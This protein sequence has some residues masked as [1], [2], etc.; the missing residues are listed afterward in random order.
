MKFFLMLILCWGIAACDQK[1]S[2]DGTRERATAEEEANTKVANENLAK[3]AEKMEKD[4]AARHRFYSSLQG[5]YEGALQVNNEIYKISFTFVPSIPPYTGD[6]VRQLSEIENELNNLYFDIDVSQWHSSDEQIVVKCPVSRIRPNMDRGTIFILST[7]CRNLYKIS[8]SED[9][10]DVSE[11]NTEKAE[12]VA[13]K[14][15]DQQLLV[16]PSLIV[17]AQLSSSASKI[18]FTVERK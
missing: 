12:A 18:S 1:S 5:N 3:K 11:K 4:L 10:I 9:G 17:T 14:I 16:V 15:K 7:E 8:L 2:T 6:R 13:R